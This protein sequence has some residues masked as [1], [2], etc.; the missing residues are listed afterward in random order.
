MG[1][2]LRAVVV[3]YN[4]GDEVVPALRAVLASEWDGTL[5]VVVVDNGSTDGSRERIAAELPE[6]RIIRSPG[7]LGYP[8]LNQAL[9]DLTGVDLVAIVNPDA[10]VEPTCLR[11]LAAALTD[12]VGAACPKILLAGDYREIGL[13]VAGPPRTSVELLAVTGADQWHL[14]GPRVRRRWHR[15]VAWTV[16]DGSVLR[17]TAEAGRPV[18]LTVRAHTATI[19][20]LTSGE[21]ET[22]WRVGRRPTTVE[23]AA[24]GA[25]HP[26]VQNA[27]SVIGPHGLGFNRGYH[28]P[29]GPRWDVPVE[30]PAW[31][32]A[33]VV[34]RTDYLQDV[35][36][37]DPRWFL[38]Y[39]DTEL[40][41]RGLLRGWRQVYVPTAVVRHAHSTTIGHGSAVYDVQHLRNRLLTLAKLAPAGEVRA[42][43]ADAARLV[44]AQLRADVVARLRDRRAP[45]PVLT[46]RRLRAMAAAARLTPVLRR[47]RSTLVAT[48]VVPD[49]ELPVLGRWRDPTEEDSC[50]SSS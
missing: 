5:E 4:G 1:R 36:L 7:N 26:V 39:E 16:G 37:M 42:A 2:T 29:A 27:G 18:R 50:S 32:G 31:C 48:G 25:A 17:T 35:G 6:V 19:L 12:R 28:S 15:G 30:V 21:A 9:T 45:E 23:V 14:T 13:G 47:E 33:A 40:A 43:W 20:T 3:N 11:E 46:V 44:L 49:A 8:A 38:Y 24:G 10:V 41:W 34:L 22:R